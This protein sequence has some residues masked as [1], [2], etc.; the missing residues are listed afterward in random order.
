MMPIAESSRVED[1]PFCGLSVNMDDPDTLYPNGIG[2]KIRSD[3]MTSYHSFRDV[4][5]E[6]WCYSIHC[7][8]TAGGCGAEI[9]GN[10]KQECIDKWN[11]RS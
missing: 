1:C 10:S 2:W 4:P 6:Q 11:R 5:K 7:V 9:S 8:T 3:G